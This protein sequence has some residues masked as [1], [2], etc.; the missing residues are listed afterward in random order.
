VSTSAQKPTAQAVAPRDL[1]TTQW[2]R[3]G[4]TMK[5]LALAA[6]IF[7]IGVCFASD[8]LGQHFGTISDGSCSCKTRCD[9]GKS[10]F[11]PGHTVEQCRRMCV[12]A[13]S[14]CTAGEIRSSQRRD[15]APVPQRRAAR[16]LTAP[17]ATAPSARV[18]HRVDCD[19]FGC[20]HQLI[21]QH[22]VSGRN[23]KHSPQGIHLTSNGGIN[24]TGWVHRPFYR[25]D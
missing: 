4:T 6:V 24:K 1:I 16:S 7:G 3:R 2:W 23:C 11:S 14:G 8:A 20:R 5:G 18:G 15:V 17:S 21:S 19:R 13:Y 25:C 22:P 9:G 12:K 10:R